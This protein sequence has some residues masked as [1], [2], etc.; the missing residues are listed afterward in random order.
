MHNLGKC[1]NS[2]TGLHDS[3]VLVTGT[4][5]GYKNVVNKLIFLLN[6]QARI[7]LAPATKNSA[8]LEPSVVPTTNQAGK[9]IDKANSERQMKTQN[10]GENTRFTRGAANKYISNQV[11]NTNNATPKFIS[12]ETLRNAA[13]K[14]ELKKK[15]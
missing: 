14:R 15:A 2:C 1:T 8:S 11:E 9:N 3:D 4:V 5:P 10:T 12:P 7:E 6:M 13:K